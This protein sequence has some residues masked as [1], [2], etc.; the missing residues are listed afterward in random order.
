[1]KIEKHDMLMA[2]AQDEKCGGRVI[3]RE[4]P[5]S[6]GGGGGRSDRVGAAWALEL[7]KTQK[8]L[9]CSAYSS[10]VVSGSAFVSAARHAAAAAYS[11]TQGWW[12]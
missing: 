6:V 10:R 9:T 12:A 5:S 1:M 3:L 2:A 4:A 8:I 11:S 7:L